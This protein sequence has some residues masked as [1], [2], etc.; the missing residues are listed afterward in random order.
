MADEDQLYA[1]EAMLG[2]LLVTGV[3]VSA[4][5]LALGLV[6]WLAGIVGA[7]LL[8]MGGLILLMATPIMRVALSVVEYVRLGD[9]LFSIT[10]LVVLM[11]LLTSVL[12]ALRG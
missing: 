5:L 12:V 8:M 3:V 2:R 7:H 4:T 1:F 10:T 6:V 9:W 11:V